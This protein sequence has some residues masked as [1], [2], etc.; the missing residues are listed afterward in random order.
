M[1]RGDVNVLRSGL[2]SRETFAGTVRGKSILKKSAV[3]ARKDIV[4]WRMVA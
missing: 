2:W 3:L 4:D 1:P